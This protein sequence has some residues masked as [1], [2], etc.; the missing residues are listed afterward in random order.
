MSR[1]PSRIAAGR[2]LVAPPSLRRRLVPATLAL[3]VALLVAPSAGAQSAVPAAPGL[4][5]PAVV[6]APA[7]PAA[8]SS[9]A[10]PLLDGTRA[11]VQTTVATDE[12]AAGS[13][14]LQERRRRFSQSTILMIVGAAAIIIGA[15]TDSDADTPL[16]LGGAI[17]GLTG[18]YLYL[19]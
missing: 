11:G 6:A 12:T 10:G 4:D 19:R 3:V 16:I 9:A 8:E 7:A 15:T 14:L 17:V 5:A 18:L 2:V 13:A 1:P